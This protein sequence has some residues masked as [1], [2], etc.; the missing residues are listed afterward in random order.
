MSGNARVVTSFLVAGEPSGPTSRPI[1]AM[2][3]DTMLLNI[4]N[5]SAE[6]REGFSTLI[7]S[8]VDGRVLSGVVVE[9]DKNVIVL[10]GSD[11]KDTITA[12]GEIGNHAHEP[13]LDHARRNAQKPGRIRRCATCSLTCGALSP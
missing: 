12:R 10:R 8:T 2:I 9:Q 5:P 6:I 1:A 3:W 7:L 11:G 13:G 4:V